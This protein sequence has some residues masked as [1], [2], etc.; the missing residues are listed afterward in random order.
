LLLESQRPTS[1]KSKKSANKLPFGLEIPFLTEVGPVRQ[2]LLASIH[3][4]SESKNG[5]TMTFS[6]IVPLFPG[7]SGI[8]AYLAGW[9]Y[10]V[11]YL[12]YTLTYSLFMA[13]AP[14]VDK[15]LCLSIFKNY[16]I[17]LL[18]LDKSKQNSS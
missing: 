18:E 16:D 2:Q 11:L 4:P 14:S 10:C 1:F 6:V 17:I 8:I 9:L 3:F 15:I 12:A 7:T 5:V 13:G